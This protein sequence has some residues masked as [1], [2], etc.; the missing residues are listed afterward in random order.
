MEKKEFD[1]VKIGERVKFIRGAK[2]NSQ[3][4]NQGTITTKMEDHGGL[5]LVVKGD[6]GIREIVNDFTTVGIGC[7]R[8]KETK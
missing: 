8:L 6:S 3:E 5:Y 4:A 1:N 7:Y 2:A